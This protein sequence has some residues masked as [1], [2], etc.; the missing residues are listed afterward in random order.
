MTEVSCHVATFGIFLPTASDQVVTIAS[1]DSLLSLIGR[2]DQNLF[3]KP[4]IQIRIFQKTN[5]VV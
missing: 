4:L 3:Q 2:T 1:R 5:L